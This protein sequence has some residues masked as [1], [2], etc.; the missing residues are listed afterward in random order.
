MI[1]DFELLGRL[2][3]QRKECEIANGEVLLTSSST[4]NVS[5]H[6]P[7]TPHSPMETS[8]ID[9]AISIVMSRI[10]CGSNSWWAGK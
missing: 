9:R 3:S 6:Q 8:E 7:Q 4:Y 10:Q 5:Y 2:M 1:D